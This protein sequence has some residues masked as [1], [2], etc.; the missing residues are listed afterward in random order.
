MCQEEEGVET[1]KPEHG[2]CHG[3]RES[4]ML[5]ESGKEKGLVGM[6]RPQQIHHGKPCW[7]LPWELM[8]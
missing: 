4:W 5:G 2:L 6:G 3:N 1:G 7:R 8:R